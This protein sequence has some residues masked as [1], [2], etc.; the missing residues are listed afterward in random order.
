MPPDLVI[1]NMRCHLTVYFLYMLDMEPLRII[2][3]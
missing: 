1:Y 2:K 3:Y